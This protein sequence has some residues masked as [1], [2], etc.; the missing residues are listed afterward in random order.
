VDD[1]VADGSRACS[2]DLAEGAD[3]CRRAVRLD[4]RELE[5]RRASVDDENVL[6]RLN[7]PWSERYAGAAP[8][9]LLLVVLPGQVRGHRDD[10]GYAENE[11]GDKLCLG[12]R[13]D[14]TRERDLPVSDLHV[15]ALGGDPQRLDDHVVT[16]LAKQLRVSAREGTYQIAGA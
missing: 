13:L 3:G 11:L 10:A 16:D 9:G 5:A 1:A 6:R 12:L 8:L 7:L 14:A 4:E 15:D 2:G